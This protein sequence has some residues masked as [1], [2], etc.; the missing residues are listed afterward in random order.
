M[1]TEESIRSLCSYGFAVFPLQANGSRPVQQGW[2]KAATSLPEI[3]KM[4]WSV[5]PFNIGIATGTPSA[6]LVVVDIDDPSACA[7]FIAQ[8]DPHTFTVK[9][10]RGLHFYY[11]NPSRRRTMVGLY[12]HVDIRGEGGLVVAPGS[13]RDGAGYTIV[14]DEAPAPLPEF[15]VTAIPPPV[16]RAVTGGFRTIN[17]CLEESPIFASLIDTLITSAKKLR[18]GERNSQ[19]FKVG[20]QVAEFVAA[21]VI[22]PSRLDNLAEAATQSGLAISEATRTVNSAWKAVTGKDRR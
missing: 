12:P 8:L 9:T 15:L 18:E 22:K 2:Q 6:G 7:E 20:C 13:I 16:D 17:P 4:F 5:Y 1:T 11:R 3:A 19:L 10:P 14:C 21:G